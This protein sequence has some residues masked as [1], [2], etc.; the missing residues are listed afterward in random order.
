[1]KHSKSL[2]TALTLVI[3]LLFSVNT[4]AQSKS[5]KKDF[6]IL[7]E[8]TDDGVKMKCIRGCAWTELVFSLNGRGPQS[9]DQFGTF[10]AESKRQTVDPKLLDFEFSISRKN[11]TFVLNGLKGT[12]WQTL[13][14]TSKSSQFFNKDGLLRAQ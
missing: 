14:L 4:T 12:N 3:T 10:N 1:M 8:K 7:V 11:N 9:V 6:T 2:L 13:S 5:Q